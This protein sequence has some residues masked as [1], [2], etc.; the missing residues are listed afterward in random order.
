MFQTGGNLIKKKIHNIMY[1]LG[2]HLP[3]MRLKEQED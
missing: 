2:M 1:L 3:D